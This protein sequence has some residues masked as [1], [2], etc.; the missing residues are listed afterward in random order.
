M[1]E[2]SLPPAWLE[3][4]WRRE[5]LALD[6]GPLVE[7]SQV[8]WLQVGWFFADLRVPHTSGDPEARDL[9]AAQAFSGVIDYQAPQLTW[10]HDLDT[11]ERSAGHADTATVELHDGV[12]RERGDGYLEEWRREE[13]PVGAAVIQR[14]AAG[15]G[16]VGARI[17]R[18]GD[19]ALAVW[20]D[21]A[22]A[23]AAMERRSGGWS[24]NASVGSEPTAGVT[25]SLETVL[26]AAEDPTAPLP[27]GWR[28]M[29]EP[30]RGVCG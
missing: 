3:G 29:T 9:D 5:G 23:G 27:D 6:G 12:L 26:Q 22:P 15:T 20:A 25:L 14:D 13:G 28:L 1:A 19:R 7:R 18:V 2:R 11:T 17:V 8:L 24:V 10:H 21:P 16:A 4:A 30:G